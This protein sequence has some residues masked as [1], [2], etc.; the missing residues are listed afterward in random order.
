MD[1]RRAVLYTNGRR[2]GID[3][4]RITARYSRTPCVLL[5]LL[6]L[7]CARAAGGEA[8]FGYVDATRV[9]MRTGPSTSSSV[10]MRFE[11]GELVEIL[12][13]SDL[14]PGESH[15]WFRV[16]TTG[17]TEGWVFGKYLARGVLPPRFALAE[18]EGER[19]ILLHCGERSRLIEEAL[20]RYSTCVMNGVHPI[21]CEGMREQSPEWNHRET[22]MQFERI[23]GLVFRVED[24]PIS[25]PLDDIVGDDVLLVDESYMK[26]AE[27]IP[28]TRL[29]SR[30]VGDDVKKTFE[31][32]YDRKLKSIVR[33]ANAGGLSIYAMEFR[34]KGRDAL[35][36][37]ALATPEGV[38]RLDFPAEWDEGSTWHVDDG[39]DF[40][41][42]LYSAGS[43]VRR[44][45][46][47]LFTLHN[48]AAESFTSRL[49][50]SGEGR[51]VA[52]AGYISS[53]YISPE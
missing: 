23:G 12:E 34:P 17:G 22:A 29:K 44:E 45:E 50:F 48:S 49:V 31:R 13:E 47:Y 5:A 32:L 36:V 7:F 37:V 42:D 24:D 2:K 10:E 43:L 25:E 27:V 18:P 8:F 1:I 28:L 9:N 6:V 46:D 19:V 21:A 33:I 38:L 16:S 3:S 51:L 35:G 53:R 26:G 4:M 11:G 40:H 52:P 20:P 15:A 39:G 14:K 30:K 41:P